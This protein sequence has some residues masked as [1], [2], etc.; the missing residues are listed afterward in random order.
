MSAQTLAAV[1]SSKTDIEWSHN[2]KPVILVAAMKNPTLLVNTLNYN[3]GLLSHNL[4]GQTLMAMIITPNIGPLEPSM[5]SPK[6]SGF[7]V[8]T[9]TQ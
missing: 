7:S 3:S 2:M 1:L 8:A 6:I 9:A 5:I 4:V